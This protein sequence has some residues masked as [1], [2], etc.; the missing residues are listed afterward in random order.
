MKTMSNIFENEIHSELNAYAM[1]EI[2]DYDIITT[3]DSMKGLLNA[4]K[5]LWDIEQ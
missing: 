3:N 5:E 4:Y 1:G 2:P